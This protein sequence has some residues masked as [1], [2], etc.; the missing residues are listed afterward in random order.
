MAND[1]LNKI[2]CKTIDD[3]IKKKNIVSG[4][5]ITYVCY[6]SKI[7]NK[8]KK[9]YQVTYNNSN[10]VVK[11]KNIELNL[12]DEIHLII[13]QGNFKDKYVLEDTCYN[14]LAENNDIQ[15]DENELET[16]VKNEL[17]GE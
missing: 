16:T 7:C 13:P 12:Y 8:E 5:D 9:I 3:A 4:K 6:V 14:H 15:I 10:Y 17:K 1:N 2:I 11:L